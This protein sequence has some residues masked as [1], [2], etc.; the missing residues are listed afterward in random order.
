MNNFKKLESK[1][2]SS[3]KIVFGFEGICRLISQ[4][5]SLDFNSVKDG[6][7]S[8]INYTPLISQISD[9]IIQSE[10]YELIEE[11]QYFSKETPSEA[12]IMNSP[13][14]TEEGKIITIKLPAA[15]SEI[16]AF[17][18]WII[19]LYDE[20]KCLTY[21]DKPLIEQLAMQMEEAINFNFEEAYKSERNELQ[22]TFLELNTAYQEAYSM[23]YKEFLTAETKEET[24]LL[25]FTEYISI[26]PNGND[27]QVLN[28][29]R[30]HLESQGLLGE[31]K[32]KFQNQ[33]D[34]IISNLC[35]S[36]YIGNES[37]ITLSTAVEFY[38]YCMA[39]GLINEIM[40]KHKNDKIKS[41]QELN[42]LFHFFEADKRTEGKIRETFRKHFNAGF[43][44]KSYPFSNYELIY[45]KLQKQVTDTHLFELTK[46]NGNYVNPNFD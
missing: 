44:S 2:P 19:D 40:A 20:L 31:I 6:L 41:A 17:Q 35:K 24:Y 25:S 11:H 30:K 1:V 16:L 4:S 27:L 36:S 9:S 15:I 43:G 14:Y 32:R 29:M 34:Y 23:V 45:D 33:S 37:K 22:T 42:D 12:D 21:K 7:H 13:I 28:S 3:K 18:E 39:I 38:C 26:A 46:R 10:M 5:Y 8:A